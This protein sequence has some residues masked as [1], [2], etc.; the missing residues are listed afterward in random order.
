MRVILSLILVLTISGCGYT[1]SSKFARTVMGEKIST[2]IR[3]SAQDP[4]NT[5]LIKDAVDEAIIE[6]FHASLRSRDESDT[7]LDISISN[8]IYVPIVY[9]KDGFVIGY[10]MSLNLNIIRHHSG[11][12]KSYSHSGTY[13]FAVSPNAVVT[14]QERFEAIKFSAAKAIESFVAK[15][16]AEGATAQKKSK[17][18]G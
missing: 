13:D 16:S 7:H 10:K 3:I 15:V 14:D 6:V 8:P 4:E 11:V 12:S 18:K 17:S 1:P 2:S 5:V 9:D